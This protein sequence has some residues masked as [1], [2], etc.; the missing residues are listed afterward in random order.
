[1]SGWGLPHNRLRLTSGA[2]SDTYARFVWGTYTNEIGWTSSFVVVVTG[3]VNPG[4]SDVLPH[5]SGRLQ[6]HQHQHHPRLIHAH[7]DALR[8]QTLKS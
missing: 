3:A 7:G 8:S 2:L 1:M 5:Q 4:E 6:E